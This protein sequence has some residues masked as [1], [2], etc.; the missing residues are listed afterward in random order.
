MSFVYKNID[1]VNRSRNVV[2]VSQTTNTSSAGVDCTKLI[3]GSQNTNYWNSV[4]VLFY[5]SGSP[6][7]NNVINGVDQ[8]DLPH[9]NFTIQNGV[10]NPQHVNKFHGYPSSS[11]FSISQHYY[12]DGIRRGSFELKDNSHPSGT[13]VIVDDGYGNL[14]GI[15]A[16]ISE[17]ATS[18]LS[19]SANYVGNIFYNHG[20][21]VV[22]TSG[23]YSHTPSQ[24]FITVGAS[25]QAHIS[26]SHFFVTGSDLS[27]SVKFV[28]TGSAEVDTS[29]VKYFKSG[30]TT[31]ITAA[32]ASIKINEVFAGT[33]ISASSVANIITMSNDANLLFGRVPTNRNDN[34]PP[35]SGAGGFNTTVGFSNGKANI[36][37]TEIGTNYSI[38]F[39]STNTVYTDEYSVTVNPNE[40]NHSMNYTLRD[41]TSGSGL[42]MPTDSSSFIGEAYELQNEF[43]SSNF[44][45]YITQVHLY[46]V[47]DSQVPVITAKLPKPVRVSNK[48]SQ[49]II[50]KIDK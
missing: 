34:L 1:G 10:N 38:K 32:S 46:D 3:S 14:Y 20:F 21:A 39:D 26:G 27:T 36:D 23:S 44:Q 9:T 8:F 17:S 16:S 19:S 45:P 15:S 25:N 24:A 41:F 30:S 31:T 35:I 5:T 49:K 33:H 7:L 18:A 48:I 13:V 29:T 37:Y 4:N 11:L 6:T 22:T 28:S 42:T 43:T 50:L 2:Y 40:F 47:K 12:G